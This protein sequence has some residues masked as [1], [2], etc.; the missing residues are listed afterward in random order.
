MILQLQGQNIHEPVGKLYNIV[1]GLPR[2]DQGH[3]PDQ[4]VQVQELCHWPSRPLRPQEH[5]DGR[6]T[7]W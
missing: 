7:Y 1:A 6:L 2:G 5:T 4:E 3:Q